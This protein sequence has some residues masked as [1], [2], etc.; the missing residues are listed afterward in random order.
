MQAV[1]WQ[2]GR[3]KINPIFPRYLF[4]QA[5]RWNVVRDA[6]RQELG[7]VITSP[8]TGKPLSLPPGALDVLLAQCAPNGVIY[9]AE[10]RAVRRQDHVRV[11]AGPLADFHG[12]CERT[13]RDRVW[14]LLTVL[15]R[16]SSV[17]FRR[18]NVAL[19][20]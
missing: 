5:Y 4:V 18:E 9:P 14:V 16:P 3:T 20:A 15:G 2:N 10:P 17:E 19:S 7:R 12:I 13:T 1:K 6:G 11:L 8:T